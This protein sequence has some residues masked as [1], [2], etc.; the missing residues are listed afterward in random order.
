MWPF[1]HKYKTGDPRKYQGLDKSLESEY[2]MVLHKDEFIDS[3]NGV[4]SEVGW[5]NRLTY[6]IIPDTLGFLNVTDCSDL[7]DVD[8]QVPDRFKTIEDALKCKREADDRYHRNLL[9]RIREADPEWDGTTKNA[10]RLTRYR[11]MGAHIHYK[12]IRSCGEESFL[13]GKIINGKKYGEDND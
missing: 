7:H 1:N 12:A 4:G 11:L 8:Y 5:K 3:C 13:D 6:H 2:F 9:T 10:G